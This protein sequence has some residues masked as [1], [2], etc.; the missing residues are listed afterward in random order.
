MSYS[1]SHLFKLDPLLSAQF[2]RTLM[3]PARVQ[4][5]F[6][7]LKNGQSNFDVIY[8]NIPLS[9][10]SV[11][12]HIRRLLDAHLLVLQDLGNKTFYEVNPERLELYAIQFRDLARELH[13]GLEALK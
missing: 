13:L 2:C 4:I 5:I 10:P 7:L 1:R 3:H 9:R 6:F 8:K 11:S 12:Q